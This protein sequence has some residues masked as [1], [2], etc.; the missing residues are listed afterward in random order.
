M[1]D[2][3]CV[4]SGELPT[5]W[6]AVFHR[7]E[8]RLAKAGLRIRVRLARLDDLPEQWDLLV[9]PPELRDQTT[10]I[11]KGAPVIVATRAD[12]G[13]AAED[14]VRELEAGARLRADRADPKAPKI[15]T[16]RGMEEL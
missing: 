7:F 2:V 15:V 1:R 10:A 6:L 3:V 5:A 4:F 11:A 8:K 9:A 16:H 12:A 13:T 14:L